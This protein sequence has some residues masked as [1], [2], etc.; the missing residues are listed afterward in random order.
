LHQVVDPTTIDSLLRYLLRCSFP[1]SDLLQSVEATDEVVLED[2][3]AFLQG[4]E[5]LLE[6]SRNRV[7]S[8][9]ALN[10]F[11]RTIAEEFAEAMVRNYPLVD[12]VSLSG[13]V[14]SGGYALR[15]DIDIDLFV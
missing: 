13:S 6:E 15:D 14:A 2:V 9:R 10:G 8:H 5:R 12:C 4:N 1:V 11:A 7:E 3:F